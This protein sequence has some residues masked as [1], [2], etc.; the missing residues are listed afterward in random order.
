VAPAAADDPMTPQ[1]CPSG[2]RLS[3]AL[4][5]VAYTAPDFTQLVLQALR[6][7]FCHAHTTV[8]GGSQED[9]TAVLAARLSEI[10]ARADA[11][12]GRQALLDIIDRAEFGG[13]D[14]DEGT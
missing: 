4:G 7:R 14:S 9:L 12:A 8:L 5:G 2:Q 10:A 11:A 1:G 3:D 6:G 13:Y